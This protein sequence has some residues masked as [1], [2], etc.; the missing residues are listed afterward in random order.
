MPRVMNENAK[1]WN[2]FNII[3]NNFLFR[4]YPFLLKS[5]LEGLQLYFSE[6]ELRRLGYL[7][8]LYIS[9]TARKCPP[10]LLQA[11]LTL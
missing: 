3:R 6:S 2:I 11:L 7:Y 4:H 5:Y 1:V 10:F 9:E 8:S